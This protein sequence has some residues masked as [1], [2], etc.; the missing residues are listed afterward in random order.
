METRIA[1]AAREGGGRIP[2]AGKENLEWYLKGQGW[3]LVTSDEYGTLPIEQQYYQMKPTVVE[4]EEGLYKIPMTEKEEAD[5]EYRERY[6]QWQ[7]EE[8]ERGWGQ[9]RQQSWWDLQRQ[10]EMTRQ[11]QYGYG[12][13]RMA[14]QLGGSSGDIREA[15]RAQLGKDWQI[16]QNRLAGEATWPQSEILRTQENPYERT[17]ESIGDELQSIKGEW[18]FAKEKADWFRKRQKDPDDPLTAG[19]G[20][21]F[22][23]GAGVQE[24]WSPDQQAAY[25]AF[26]SEAVTRKNYESA[27][28]SREGQDWV[29]WKGRQE[30]SRA[31][32]EKAGWGG[33]YGRDLPPKLPPPMPKTPEFLRG[34]YPELGERLPR[35]KE[36]APMYPLSGQQ[37]GGM[38]PSQRQKWAGYIGWAGGK[39]QDLYAQ[40]K[41]MQPE[42]RR[43][44]GWKPLKQWGF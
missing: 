16:W 3:E 25:G 11:A 42:P 39:P 40:M 18:E 6:F 9:Q 7:Q 26:L 41:G 10:R 2:F 8:A 29:D 23:I 38:L 36:Q 37:W 4:G 1:A 5:A 13:Q 31:V 22:D 21:Y 34:V 15:Q 17:P 24:Q 20:D 44:G 27:M 28:M 14:Y 43:G 19:S 35:N 30:K 32:A 12:Q 33:D